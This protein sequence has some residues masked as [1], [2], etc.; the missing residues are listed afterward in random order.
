MGCWYRCAV[1][2]GDKLVGAQ[3][4]KSAPLLTLL[5]LGNNQLDEMVR[6]C[7]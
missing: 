6:P 2:L 5:H 3:G 4:L 1:S 7:R